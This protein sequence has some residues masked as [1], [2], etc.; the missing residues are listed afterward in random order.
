MTNYSN[1]ISL[2]VPCMVDQF[3]PSVARAS[4]RVLGLLGKPYHVASFL[5][6]TVN[7]LLFSKY[8]FYFVYDIKRVKR[9]TQSGLH[10]ADFKQS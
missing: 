7:L 8:L 9:L 4:E 6:L 3:R 1:K 2:F 5:C 10:P